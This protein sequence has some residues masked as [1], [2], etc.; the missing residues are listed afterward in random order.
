MRYLCTLGARMW[1]RIWLLANLLKIFK[2]FS[3]IFQNGLLFYQNR[4]SL[5]YVYNLK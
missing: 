5:M 2:K 4:N 3:N 1:W